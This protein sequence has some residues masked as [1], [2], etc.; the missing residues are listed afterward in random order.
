LQKYSYGVIAT[1]V[2]MLLAILAGSMKGQD[3]LGILSSMIIVSAFFVLWIFLFEKEF[4]NKIANIVKMVFLAL[5]FVLMMIGIAELGFITILLALPLILYI[6][7][8]KQK[9]FFSR[10]N[11]K[12]VIST[13]KGKVSYGFVTIAYIGIVFLTINSK[14]Y[15]EIH[16]RLGD[17]RSQYYLAQE[18]S[19][20][21]RDTK[22]LE[23]WQSAIYWHRKAAENGWV[24]SMYELGKLN[25]EDHSP[26]G[27][28][29]NTNAVELLKKTIESQCGD[30]DD[31][32]K[33]AKS[34]ATN[35]L[36]HIYLIGRKGITKDYIESKHWY[37]KCLELAWLNMNAGGCNQKLAAFYMYGWGV[38]PNINLSVDYYKKA[39]N[40]NDGLSQNILGNMYMRAQIIP[41]D[42]AEGYKWLLLS[43]QE[44]YIDEKTKKERD[45]ELNAAESSLN[46]F[47][48]SVVVEG[49][50][51]AKEWR[52]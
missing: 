5:A 44:P 31:D 14:Y 47:N 19:S 1:A 41:I 52:K 9:R 27:Y 25:M 42:F 33:Y 7:D 21:F 49:Q 15:K 3:V 18:Y 20:K 45:D 43:T 51:R 37:E 34:E 39:A 38:A 46:S 26:V 10:D 40:F 23:D 17:I 6:G 28:G 22:L 30:K 50:R 4:E 13:I 11:F 12:V 48:P 35:K 29:Y 16:A 8:L 24:S 2:S 32:C 36:G